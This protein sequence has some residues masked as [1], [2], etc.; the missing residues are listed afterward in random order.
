MYTI[1][2]LITGI[3]VYRAATIADANKYITEHSFTY[4]YQ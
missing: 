3:A 4:F 2:S 1:Y